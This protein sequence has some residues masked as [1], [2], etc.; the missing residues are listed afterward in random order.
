MIF[1]KFDMIHGT[2]W[3]FLLLGLMIVVGTLK[4]TVQFLGNMDPP[5]ALCT[6]NLTG[7][8]PLQCLLLEIELPKL[9]IWSALTSLPTPAR[10]P[11][12]VRLKSR[13]RCIIILFTFKILDY[14]PL[15]KM[16][17]YSTQRRF[18]EHELLNI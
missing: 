13:L 3:S 4:N 12:S 10:L 17:K 8:S 5:L 9:G 2:L 6:S 14:W 7:N 15:W 16:L 11:S 18:V 1:I